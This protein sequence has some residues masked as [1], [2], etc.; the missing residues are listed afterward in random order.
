MYESIKDKMAFEVS[1]YRTRTLL[2]EEGSFYQ[3]SVFITRIRQIE[4]C[5]IS[6]SREWTASEKACFLEKRDLLQGLLDELEGEEI[7][8]VQVRMALKHMLSQ[9]ESESR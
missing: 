2:S 8:S 6:L 3:K 4:E 1:K 5:I 7:S 9:Y